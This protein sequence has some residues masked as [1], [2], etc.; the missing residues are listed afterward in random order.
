MFLKHYQD[1]DWVLGVMSLTGVFAVGLLV[2]SLLKLLSGAPP[3]KRPRA[4]SSSH[5]PRPSGAGAEG[6]QVE[7]SAKT[8]VALP[9]LDFIE[10]SGVIETLG[11]GSV[12]A[13]EQGSPP[14]PVAV[15]LTAT[16]TASMVNENFIPKQFVFISRMAVPE[17]QRLQALDRVVA[18]LP[19]PFRRCLILS[20]LKIKS[21][22][23]PYLAYVG[24]GKD[25]DPLL[26]RD[27]YER[28]DLVPQL[29]QVS[30]CSTFTQR[31]FQSLLKQWL[32]S[33]DLIVCYQDE[34]LMEDLRG[35]IARFGAAH[36]MLL[37]K[38]SELVSDGLNGS[39]LE[40]NELVSQDHL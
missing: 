24:E 36:P 38:S 26:C 1:F 18:Q 16:A 8:E 4:R 10:T 39:S 33:Y 32:E 5:Q 2:N 11:A 29:G 25:L 9:H 20:D 14:G 13:S 28:I 31:R 23:L 34:S 37:A 35:F 40:P 21:V 12:P 6:T 22:D 27:L 17:R 7:A 3:A 15:A 30:A 19:S